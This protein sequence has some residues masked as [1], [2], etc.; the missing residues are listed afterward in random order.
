MFHK[1]SWLGDLRAFLKNANRWKISWVYHEQKNLWL[2]VSSDVLIITTSF[3]ILKL[4]SHRDFLRHHRFFFWKFS[5]N[6]LKQTIFVCDKRNT[7]QKIYICY[8]LWCRR[9]IPGHHKLWIVKI[10]T[11]VDIV[12]KTWYELL[13]CFENTFF[14]F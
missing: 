12:H 13:T 14:S 3:K 8:L 1:N 11:T 7:F 10:L 2:L 5:Q 9:K 4:K 6:F